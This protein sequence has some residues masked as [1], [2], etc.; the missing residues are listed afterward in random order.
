MNNLQKELISVFNI[1]HDPIKI[2]IIDTLKLYI[3]I[4]TEKKIFKIF[5]KYKE[6][7]V[8]SDVDSYIIDRILDPFFMD[9]VYIS[10]TYYDNYLHGLY[11]IL[12]NPYLY[13][14]Y[15]LQALYDN[16]NIIKVVPELIECCLGNVYSNPK[17]KNFF[18]EL[19]FSKWMES[20][21]FEKV[22][23]ENYIDTVKSEKKTK[24]QLDTYYSMY[25]QVWNVFEKIIEETKVI[26]KKYYDKYKGLKNIPGCINVSKEFYAY[27][28]EA[29]VGLPLGKKISIPNL[30][31]WGIKEFEKVK[32]LMKKTMLN[33][34]PQFEK[35]SVEEMIKKINSMQKYKYNSREEYIEDH[36]NTMKKYRDFFV[37][38][39]KFPLLAEP[40][41]V[42]FNE[43]KKAGAYWWLDT[44][45]L[46]SHRWEETMKFDVS[47]LVLHESIPG[48]HMQLS[49]ENHNNKINSL[50]LWFPIYINGYAEGWGLFAE[51]LGHDL[52]ESKY[53]G[54]LSFHMLRTLRIIADIAIHYYGIDPEELLKFFKRYLPMPE[55]SIRSEIYRYV[56]LPGQALCYK[57]GDEII[58]RTFINKFNRTNELLNDDSIQFFKQLI[59]DGTMPLEI[60]AKKYSTDVNF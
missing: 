33:L 44:F 14:T 52:D 16:Q 31:Q 28:A 18:N 17:L 56:C 51:K 35:L 45:Y 60:F 50:I 10:Q 15:Q 21:D 58:K 47:A 37:N 22:S 34:E 59:L 1:E 46:N 42:H 9:S 20:F 5:K 19:L 8:L 4:L 2:S 53:I 55:E 48:H 57:M 25:S 54:V 7:S 13:S 30:L 12:N 41:F 32:L 39:K 6:S 49:Y 23:Y 36:K 11:F 24:S 29:N 27:C 43:E 38:E 40:I 26:V 3:D